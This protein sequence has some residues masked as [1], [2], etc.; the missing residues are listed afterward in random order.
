MARTPGELGEEE[1]QVSTSRTR[2]AAR[3]PAEMDSR[4][5]RV[6]EGISGLIL[7]GLG[8]SSCGSFL[9][10]VRAKTRGNWRAH[11]AWLQH[12]AVTGQ[13]WRAGL[14]HRQAQ[15]SGGL[16][17]RLHVLPLCMAQ[18][19]VCSGCTAKDPRSTSIHVL[20]VLCTGSL[21]RAGLSVSDDHAIL[22]PG[23][24]M[25]SCGPVGT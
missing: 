4:F 10:G 5:R 15:L 11:P 9:S 23:P 7:W 22:Q 12:T 16:A 24:R 21:A 1:R 13:V 19:H 6:A 18:R 20:P 8:L 3:A 2:V 14:Q 25:P 17:P